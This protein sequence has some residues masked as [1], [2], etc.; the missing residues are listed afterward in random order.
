MLR[1]YIKIAW[2]VLLRRKFFTFISL[3]AI[4]FTLTVA[5]VAAALLDHVFGPFPPEVRHDRTVGLFHISMLGERNR[6]S[7]PP[8]YG[9]LDRY[10]REV[11]NAELSSFSTLPRAVY[12]YPGGDKVKLYLKNTDGDFWRL[13]DFTFVEGAPFGREDDAQSRFVAVI[14]EA[15][16]RAY[17]GDASALGKMIELDG[18]RFVVVGVVRNVPFFRVVSFADVWVP[19]RTLK[20]DAYRQEMIGD[21]MGVFLARDRSGL[22]SIRQEVRARIAGA[23]LSAFPGFNNL[24]GTAETPFETVSRIL[25]NDPRESRPGRLLAVLLLM[26]TLFMVLPTINLVNLN[27]SRILE[28]AS[29]IGV[30]KSFGASSWTLVGQFIVENVMLTLIGGAIGMIAS[31]LVLS[32]VSASGMIPYAAFQLNLRVF[33]YG[34]GIAL[35]FGLFSGVYPAWKMSRLNPVDA[36]KG[37]KL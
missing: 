27:V 31:L 37:G 7:G 13:F 26:M 16:R 9:L 6:R 29:E 33:A 30:R 17:F 32:G 19:I 24:V 3:F 22:A 35:F 28:R 14:N 8:G 20:S 21:F 11:P 25:F 15:T 34:L 1:N 5:M 12:S 10:L 18:Q 2:K 23:D 4:S 36:L